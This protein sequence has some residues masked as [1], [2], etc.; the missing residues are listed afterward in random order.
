MNPELQAAL[1]GVADQFQVHLSGTATPVDPAAEPFDVTV[2]AVVPAATD[3]AGTASDS[4][5]TDSGSESAS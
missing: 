1:Q 3:A 4:S 2:T 5:S